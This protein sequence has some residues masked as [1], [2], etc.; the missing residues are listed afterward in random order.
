MKP[1]M[2]GQLP[3]ERI[4]PQDIFDNTGVEYAGPVYTKTGSIRKPIIMKGYMAVFV[5]FSVKAVHLE[6][7]TELTTSA[8]IATLLRFIA[9][10]GMPMTIWRDNSLNLVGAAKEMKRLVSDPELSRYCS[11]QV[12]KWKFTPEHAPQFGG[13]WEASVK[14]FKE[15]LRKGSGRN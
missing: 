7:I 2:L 15:H 6:P 9:R 4:N 5:S 10:K 12:I 14:C 1:Q 3:M 11:H 13:L 8:F